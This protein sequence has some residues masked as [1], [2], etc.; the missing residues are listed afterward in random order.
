MSI[1][2][3][4]T[5]QSVKLE[6]VTQILNTVNRLSQATRWPNEWQVKEVVARANDLE[7]TLQ[8]LVEEHQLQDR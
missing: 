4:Y 5:E 7:E 1:E 3:E 2:I 6:K 8:A